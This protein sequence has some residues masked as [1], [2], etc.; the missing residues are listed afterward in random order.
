[1]GGPNHI[2]QENNTH[3]EAEKP[4]QV[5]GVTTMHKVKSILNSSYYFQILQFYPLLQMVNI[6]SREGFQKAFHKL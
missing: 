4:N 2:C 1:M 3:Q 6:A 5:I